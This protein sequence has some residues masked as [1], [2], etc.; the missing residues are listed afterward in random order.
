MTE[1]DLVHAASETDGPQ[2][3][4]QTAVPPPLEI[5]AKANWTRAGSLPWEMLDPNMREKKIGDMRAALLALAE[6][7]LSEDVLTAGREEVTYAGCFGLGRGP[8]SAF[9]AMLREIAREGG[10][11]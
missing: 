9:R 10:K 3:G 11:T 7:E 8:S 6:A 2:N 5:M 1:D 4:Q